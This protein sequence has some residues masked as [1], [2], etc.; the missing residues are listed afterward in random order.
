MLLLKNI[1]VVHPHSK[2]HLQQVDVRIDAQGTIVQIASGLEA[3][4]D[5]QIIEHENLHLSAGWLDLGT[6]VGDP[7]L[8]TRED[9]ESLT[10][11]AVAGGFTAVA[12]LPNSAPSVDQKSAVQYVKSHSDLVD[13]LPLAAVSVHTKGKDLAELI[14]MHHAGAIAFT[15]GLHRLQDGG[16][17][18]RALQYLKT[19]DGLLIHRPQD[20][21]IAADGIVHEGAMS[22][23]LGT[24]GIPNIAEEIMVIRDLRLLEYS[25]SRLHLSGLTTAAGLAQVKQARQKGLNVSASVSSLH[26]LLDDSVLDGFDSNY[27]IDPP[28]R[29]ASQRAALQKAVVS[30]DI[31]VIQS[32]HVPHEIEQKACEF[33]YAEPG[34]S[35]LETSFAAA[36][37]ALHTEMTLSAFIACFTEGPRQV[38]NLPMP[39]FEEGATADFTLFNPSTAWTVEAQKLKSKG[40]NNP[41]IGKTLRGE[42]IGI[43]RNNQYALK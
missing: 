7:G 11:T 43:I 9:F 13:F 18:L 31:N 2:Y 35:N 41:F 28:L 21:H 29:D 8:E 33:M 24:K 39:R 3:Q 36:W 30:G 34:A 23:M 27:K 22:T 14:D 17:M 26:L 6:F 1:T 32:L 19:F 38:L 20:A 4:R 42:V 5:E 37:Q 15:D 16:L 25:Q 12:C 40:K 10:Q